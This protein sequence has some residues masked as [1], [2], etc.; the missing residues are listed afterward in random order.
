MK[1]SCKGGLLTLTGTYKLL[2]GNK[3]KMSGKLQI[4]NG[5]QINYVPTAV[6]I[7]GVPFPVSGVRM[8]LAK[9]NPLLDLSTVVMKPKVNVITV[10]SGKLTIK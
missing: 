3:F 4:K 6:K 9:I 7:N 5:Q 1:A 2:V 10:E 8:I